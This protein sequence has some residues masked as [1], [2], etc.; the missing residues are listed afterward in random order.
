MFQ[1]TSI[2]GK[3]CSQCELCKRNFTNYVNPGNSKA[4]YD[5]NNKP[6]QRKF[7]NGIITSKGTFI[8]RHK[9]KDIFPSRRSLF[10]YRSNIGVNP[11]AMQKRFISNIFASNTEELDKANR[12]AQRKKFGCDD[13]TRRN[14]DR[15]GLCMYKDDYGCDLKWAD[16]DEACKPCHKPIYMKAAPLKRLR[17]RYCDEDVPHCIAEV[18]TCDRLDDNLKL[19]AKCLP[20]LELNTCC[21]PEPHL[22]SICPK[23]EPP[24]KTYDDS[25]MPYPHDCPPSRCDCFVR[26]DDIYGIHYKKLKKFKP[27]QEQCEYCHDKILQPKILPRIKRLVPRYVD[28]DPPKPPECF[29]EPCIRPVDV[30]VR[31]RLPKLVPHECHPCEDCHKRACKGVKLK[32]LKK[33]YDDT[34]MGYRHKCP[35]PFKCPPRLD[36]NYKMKKKVLQKLRYGTCKPVEPRPLFLPKIRRLV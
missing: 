31:K 16:D 4:L 24:T 27:V 14:E 19:T 9:W 22:P 12:K 21:K 15:G 10:T 28:V 1:E 17:R 20:R 36:D 11:N 25:E 3:T 7:K 29:P 18:V 2:L 30:V 13:E 35:V 6:R 8:A 34:K 23:I 33:R 32:Q 26:L 5:L